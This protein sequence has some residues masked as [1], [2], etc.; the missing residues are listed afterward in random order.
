MRR[1]TVYLVIRDASQ[2]LLQTSR[3]KDTRLFTTRVVRDTAQS[4]TKKPSLVFFHS[5]FP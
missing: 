4:N 3:T 2:A 1:D 5:P